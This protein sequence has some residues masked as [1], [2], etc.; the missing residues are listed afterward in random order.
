MAKKPQENGPFNDNASY[1]RWEL[2]RVERRA[3]AYLDASQ[4]AG[5]G[6]LVAE[7][8]RQ[9][10]QRLS[11]L[12]YR[13]TLE[14]TGTLSFAALSRLNRLSPVDEDV[15]A[16]ASSMHLSTHTRQLL[17]HAQGVP[18][19]RELQVGFVA[20]LIHPAAGLTS[21]RAWADANAPLVRDGLLRIVPSHSSSRLDAAVVVPHH[22][23]SAV[24]GEYCVDELLEPYAELK[25]P[26]T[27]IHDVVLT[28]QAKRQVE[29]L[30]ECFGGSATQP[31]NILVHGPKA[32]GKTLLAEAFTQSDRRL[33]LT[34]RCDRLPANRAA[35]LLTLA[36]HNARLLGSALHLVRPE[37]VL[38]FPGLSGELE[39]VMATRLG[40]TIL[41]SVDVAEL[42][43][44][45]AEALHCSIGMGEPDAGAREQLWESALSPSLT[46]V[47]EVLLSELA[48]TFE[49]QGGEIRAA[50]NWAVR[51]AAA[52]SRPHK[53]THEDLEAGARQQLRVRS[54]QLTE[55][56]S[57]KL[58]MEHLILDEETRSRA[59]ALLA[60]CRNR[61]RLLGEWG[62]GRRLSTGKGLVALFHGEAGT[63]KTLCAEILASEL[64]VELQKVAM[65]EV[66]SKWVGETEKN[67]RQ[68]FSEARGRGS[69][70]LFDEAD[71]LFGKR[72]KVERAQD[73]FQNMEVNNLL[74]EIERFNGIVILTTNL[75]MNMD[76]AFARRIL[77]KIEFPMPEQPEREAI[78]RSLIPKEA[79]REND[80]DDGIEYLAE[81]FELSGGQIKNAVVRA[82]Y[83]CIEEGRALHFN[84]LLDAAHQEIASA[85]RLSRRT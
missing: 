12:E 49:L 48:H 34:V 37:C 25:R 62:F 65:P 61:K 1:V 38:H 16:I 28:T 39:R 84:A 81:K 63:G 22:V 35:E 72:V 59:E 42:E 40:L 9:R 64:G 23:A 60:A 51:R 31:L 30:M 75:E 36:V 32:C 70:L 55:G 80:L 10:T 52:K 56:T 57:V 74:Q 41:E 13:N 24:V 47:G 67:L 14:R 43:E 17:L 11:V 69:L 58:G 27:A 53:L 6:I 66:V 46:L 21:F 71:A 76:A 29:P 77:F 3:R 26:S 50:V 7:V 73:H 5:A 68:L 8:Q 2:E 78:W 20:E 18:G 79:P 15:L 19:A 44:L 33:L 85:G 83:R 4:A 82:A 45:L 54:S